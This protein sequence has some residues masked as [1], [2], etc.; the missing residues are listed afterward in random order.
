MGRLSVGLNSVVV[1]N[2]SLKYKGCTMVDIL[3]LK[4]QLMLVLSR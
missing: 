4:V 3:Q 1:E 2:V